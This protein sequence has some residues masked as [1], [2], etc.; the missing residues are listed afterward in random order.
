MEIRNALGALQL[1]PGASWDEIRTN[2]RRLLRAT[3]PDLSN[4]PDAADRT[5]RLTAAYAV[6]QKATDSGRR[7]LP[8]PTRPPRKQQ[9]PRGQSPRYS[10]ATTPP[11]HIAQQN[12]GGHSGGTAGF[13]LDRSSPVEVF[14]RLQTA[15]TSVGTLC[16]VDPE[17]LTLQI[18]VEAP[19][20]NPAQLLAE[21]TRR[22]TDTAIQFTLESLTADPGPPIRAIVNRLLAAL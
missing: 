4:T 1:G 20:S 22:G 18:L 21:V 15:A 19:G 14:S 10:T 13:V 12:P 8:N 6:L 3:H 9:A 11:G 17:T 2:Y 7:P 5:A 16:G